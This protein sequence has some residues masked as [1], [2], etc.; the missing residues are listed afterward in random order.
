MSTSV[1]I[2]EKRAVFIAGPKLGKISLFDILIS[3][4]PF[5]ESSSL[6]WQGYIDNAIQNAPFSIG[7]F[8]ITSISFSWSMR[9][10]SSRS[11]GKYMA[12]PILSI[13]KL[14]FD[15]KGGQVCYQ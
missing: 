12:R 10:V 14:F 5:Y 9:A 7:C 1:D 13:K 8:S 3:S 6:S 15:E 2:S 11:M 4:G